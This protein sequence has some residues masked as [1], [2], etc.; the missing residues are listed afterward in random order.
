MHADELLD[1]A[2]VDLD[3]AADEPF[4][5]I[6]GDLRERARLTDIGTSFTRRWLLRLLRGHADL[7]DVATEDPGVLDETIEAPVIVAGAPRTGTTFL[8]GLL[9]QVP[10]ARAPQGWE[11]LSPLPPPTRD[12]PDDDPRIVAADEE[13]TF[14]Q[15]ISEP[16]LSI[17]RYAGRMHKECLSAMSFAFRS[18]EFISRY[19][20][21]GYVEWLADADMT[22]AYDTHRRVFQVLQ[23]R[24]PTA[25]WV[26][27]SPVHLNN[28]PAVMTRYPDARIVI[29]HRDP[30]EV[31]GSVT[32]LVANLRRAFSDDVDEATIG[33]Y[34]LRL[35]GQ[36]LS[37]LGSW[38]DD[39]VVAPDRVVH[40]HQRD[41]I[42]DPQAAVDLIADRFALARTE[43]DATPP[44]E[45]GRHD[46]ALQ[47]CTPTDVA[48]TFT[49]YRTR[50]L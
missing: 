48:A 3:A 28:L 17:H 35:Y 40:V 29:T 41:L 42:A 31:L 30:A 18:E 11:L 1:E 13:L 43:V 34:H 38:L 4:R 25:R 49:P 24:Q 36:T 19:E 44:T 21:P 16:M 6:V 14:P 22:P 46:Y 47:G 7:R 5:I 2:G 39:G 32:S 33:R 23:R 8:H 20:L 37:S 26:L 27:K 12:E 9:A 50:F 45:T 15:R 10:G